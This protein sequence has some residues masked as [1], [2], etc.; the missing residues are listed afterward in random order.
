MVHWRQVDEFRSELTE[1]DTAA[2]LKLCDDAMA[3]IIITLPREM[4]RYLL[5]MAAMISVPPV[6]PPT[7]KPSIVLK[8]E[9]KGN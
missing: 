2:M 7:E 4:S 6:L 3:H 8:C 1:E 5:T 9:C